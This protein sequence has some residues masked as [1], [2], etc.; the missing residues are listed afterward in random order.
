MI[1]NELISFILKIVSH[2][3][4]KPNPFQF[5]SPLVLLHK[6][7]KRNRKALE[8]CKRMKAWTILEEIFDRFPSFIILSLLQD[9]SEILPEKWIRDNELIT[10]Q[11]VNIY[12]DSELGAFLVPR[13]SFVSDN[14]V[15][16]SKLEFLYNPDMIRSSL[17]PLFV[18]QL[19]NTSI[20][21]TI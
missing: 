1:K 10:K 16:N 5:H 9:M 11:I 17:V 19:D 6:L 13:G 18:S 15:V 20:K 7:I 12:P 2:E 8:I 3:L 21:A 14:N 4:K